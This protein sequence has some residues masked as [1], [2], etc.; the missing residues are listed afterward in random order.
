MS[1]LSEKGRSG[2][3]RRGGAVLILAA[4]VAVGGCK[5]ATPIRDLLA[6][7][8][9]YDGQQVRIAGKVESSAGALGYGV[10]RV[11]DGT[12]QINVVTKTGGAPIQGAKVGVEGTF[13]S[14]FTLGT[15]VVAVIEETK[16]STP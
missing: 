3:M 4:L 9:K 10:Y 8:G 11:D 16:R 6:N 5:G 1:H 7:T 15:D 14:A 12:G 2:T 13:H